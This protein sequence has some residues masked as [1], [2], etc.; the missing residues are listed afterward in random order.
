MLMLIL[1]MLILLFAEV[2]FTEVLFA[3]NSSLA[4]VKWE[5]TAANQG[6]PLQGR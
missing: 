6:A 4:P 5:Q 1:L 2:L 3:Q